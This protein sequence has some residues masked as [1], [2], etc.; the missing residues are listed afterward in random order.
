MST[1]VGLKCKDEVLIASDS[2]LVEEDTNVIIPGI[3]KKIFKNGKYLIGFVGELRTAQ[4]LMSKH[5]DPPEDIFDFPFSFIK[6]LKKNGALIAAENETKSCAC[7]FLVAW[8]NNLFTFDSDFS[9]MEISNY[10]AI[11]LG[12]NYVVASL[13]STEHIDMDP[14]ERVVL[15]LTVACD[16]VT[17]SAPPFFM[18]STKNGELLN[19]I[20]D[21]SQKC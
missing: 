19:G 17:T 11:G 3:H 20:C 6:I 1:V 5:F 2:I 4:L 14:K 9:L 15:A 7:D 8:D 18:Y 12:G 13:R 16:I 10:I 21:V